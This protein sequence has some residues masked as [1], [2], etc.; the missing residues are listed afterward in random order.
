[1]KNINSI[2]NL[3]ELREIQNLKHF[4]HPNLMKMIDIVQKDKEYQT[5][6]YVV[7]DYGFEIK[8]YV[9]Q[10]EIK[11][12]NAILRQIIKQSVKGVQTLH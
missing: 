7:M 5:C 9:L 2:Q 12:S 3:N 10:K 4:N 8:E 6:Y 11:P 1:M